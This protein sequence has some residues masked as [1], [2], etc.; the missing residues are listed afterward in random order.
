MNI[1]IDVILP[2]PLSDFF[3][4]HVPEEWLDK[5]EVGKRALVSFGRNKF[6]AA[7]IYRIHENKPQQYAVKDILSILDE[8]PVVN[9]LQL[10]FWEWISDYYLCTYGEVMAVALPSAF[11]LASETKIRL[12]PDFSGEI[13]DLKEKDLLIIEALVDKKTLTIGQVEKLLHKSYVISQIK[14]L[15]DKEVIIVCEEVEERYTTRK[16]VFLSLSNTYTVASNSNNQFVESQTIDSPSIEPSI[17]QDLN[18]NALSAVLNTLEKST[19]TQPQADVLLLFISALQKNK[20]TYVRKSDFLKQEPVTEAKISALIKKGIL[21]AQS[22]EVSRLELFEQKYSTE[23]IQ[24]NSFQQQALDEIQDLF[25]R[26]DK[27]LLHGVTGSGKTELYIKLIQK[28][29]NEGKQVLYLLPEIALTMQIIKRIS[30]YFGKDVG[31]YHSHF[32]DMERVEIWNNTLQNEQNGYK[33]I[34]GARSAIFLP[35]HNLGLIIVDEEHD[36]SYKQF[37]PSPRYN[38]RDAAVILAGLHHAKVCFGTATP[39]LETYFNTQQKKYGLVNLY[40]RYGGLQLPQIQ[41]IDVRKEKRKDRLHSYYTQTLIT[42]MEN[43]LAAKEQIILFQNRRGFSMHLECNL[44]G[45]VPVCKYCDVTL[46]YHK[47]GKE[48]RCHYCGY[49]EMVPAKCPQCKNNVMEMRGLGTERVEEEIMFFFPNAKVARLDYDSTRAKHAYRRI[50][51]DF[52]SGKIDILVG[53]QMVTKG[54]DFDNVSVVGILNADN[55]LN[56]PD[57]RSLE[58]SFQLMMQVSGRA[59]RKNKQG[60]VLI[61]TYKPQHEVFNYLQSN[62]YYA[63]FER[64]LKERYSFRYP[65]LTRLIKI[66]LKHK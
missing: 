57:F 13:S 63:L 61:Q 54:L 28:T 8:S 39:S 22:K 26:Q 40:Q 34:L 3:T 65:P 53:T 43:A 62:D 20:T 29:I 16:E 23:S 55:M 21:T 7:I 4:Y 37:D 46:T 6:Y 1:Y 36:Y 58:R 41:L 31:V 64:L 52:E 35:F 17:H 66:T 59:G 14:N 2:L 15:I 9:G 24:L 42:A 11:K 44:C 38:A 56:Y 60:Q 10:R 47:Q 33:V 27:V 25:Q 48:L 19:R 32:N 50:L 30:A 49:S 45:H 18:E 51:S 12:H 5:V